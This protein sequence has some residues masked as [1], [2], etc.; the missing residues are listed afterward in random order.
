MA[1]SKEQQDALNK[2]LPASAVRSR[3]GDGQSLSY[4]DGFYVYDT[5]NAIVGPG[6]WGYTIQRL[7]CVQNVRETKNGRER[8]RVAYICTVLLQLDGAQPVTDVGYGNGI[9]PDEGAAHESASK[10]AVTDAVKRCARSLGRALGLALYDKAQTHVSHEPDL[11]AIAELREAVRLG[12]VDLE[13]ESP[14]AKRA[15]MG[16]WVRAGHPLG[17]TQETIV[18]W[19]REAKEKAS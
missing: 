11:E 5:L 15:Q 3:Q 17:V 10:E 18:G 6:S 9:N 7:D 13:G 8:S 12:V 1:L 2:D 16:K 19:A 4:V 14:E